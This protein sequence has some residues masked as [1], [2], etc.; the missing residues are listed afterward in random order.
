MGYNWGINGIWKIFEKLD[1]ALEWHWNIWSASKLD[2]KRDAR[3]PRCRGSSKKR[4]VRKRCSFTGNNDDTPELIW[5]TLIFRHIF[6]MS[7]I[8]CT[9]DSHDILH[10]MVAFIARI[11]AWR[12]KAAVARNRIAVEGESVGKPR[13]LVGSDLELSNRFSADWWFQR[14]FISPYREF[15]HPNWLS[16]IFQ[17]G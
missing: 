10:K 7:H 9:W 15:H 6:D 17:D 14:L 5:A 2:G 13:G 12:R 16:H 3:V 4:R 11:G 1:V 8:G